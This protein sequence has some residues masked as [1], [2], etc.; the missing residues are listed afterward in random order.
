MPY[1]HYFRNMVRAR[2]ER[3]SLRRSVEEAGRSGF[4]ASP[5]GG[6]LRTRSVGSTSGDH[7]ARPVS[8]REDAA[9]EKNRR[10]NKDL[11]RFEEPVLFAATPT[12]N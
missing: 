9:P 8:H 12:A 11:E 4:H 7:E 5:Q 2:S 10:G 1:L 3:D 6:K